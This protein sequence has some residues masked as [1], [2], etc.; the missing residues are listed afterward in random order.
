MKKLPLLLAAAFAAFLASG[1][2]T[3]DQKVRSMPA[4][5]FKSWSHS[6]R[7][8]L[9]TDSVIISGVSWTYNADGTATAKVDHYDGQAAWAGTVG[10]HDV[11]ESLEIIFPPTSPQAQALAHKQTPQLPAELPPGTV[12]K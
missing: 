5:N 2:S 7:Y 11:I 6:D 4:F 8:G 10:P 1:C 3:I 12:I 9:F